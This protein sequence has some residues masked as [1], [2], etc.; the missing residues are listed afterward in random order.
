MRRSILSLLACVIL[1]GCGGVTGTAQ[2]QFAS[3]SRPGDSGPPPMLYATM[4]KPSGQGPFPGMVVL[5]HCGGIDSDLHARARW[6]VGMGYAAIVP[7]SFGPRGTGSVCVSGRV[8]GMQRVADALAAA[9]Y[10]RRLPDVR[11]DRIGMIG[12]SHGAWAVVETAAAPPL[13]APFQ[14]AVAYYPYC[15]NGLAPPGVPTLVLMGAKDDWTPAAPC[16]AWGQR[17]GDPGKLNAIVYPDAYHSFDKRRYAQVPGGGGIMH[18]VRY[19]GAATAD[20]DA[21]TEAF[22]ARWLKQ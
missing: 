20:A 19:D 12:F 7:D 3:L 6:L 15:R 17:T 21:R 13:S 10:L 14:A 11:G 4:Y 16:V 2:V 9:N 5:H 18:E 1:A 22:L 8:T